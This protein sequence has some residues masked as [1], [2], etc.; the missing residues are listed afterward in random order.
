LAEYSFAHKIQK[1]STLTC[2]CTLLQYSQQCELVYAH[3]TYICNQFAVLDHTKM[4]CHLLL[5]TEIHSVRRYRTA[6]ICDWLTHF[7]LFKDQLWI[8][9]VQNFMNTRQKITN[10]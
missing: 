10:L 1:N 3:I 6:M 2:D 5:Q 8:S 7:H 9:S 4:S